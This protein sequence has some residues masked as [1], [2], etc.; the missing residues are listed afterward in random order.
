MNEILVVNSDTQTVSARELHEKLNIGT[1][2]R[3][4]FPRMAEYGFF[5]NED[6]R[7]V[8]QKCP[9]LGGVQ[10]MVDYEIS[11]DMAK[12]ICMLQRTPEGKEVR[13]YLIDLE[14]A[15]NT[16][17]QVMARA[18]KMA[19]QTIDNLQLTVS[20][21]QPKAAYFDRLVDRRLNTNIRD[22]AK[23]LKVPQKVFVAWLL[24]NG[25]CYRD[26][27]GDIRPTSTAMN[28]DYFEIKE[29]SS[30][31]GH[32]GIQTLITPR[33]REAFSIL[34]EVEKEN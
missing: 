32:S 19:Q 16:P 27:R 10:E 3:K 28:K 7:R 18:L 5:E 14:K 11:I 23:E 9:T 20:Q 13:Q 12:Q 15:W 17:E 26:I 30:D 31:N 1:E 24:N 29:Y 6:F 8:S 22:T 4:W 34:L 2:F 33:G 25:F 21:M